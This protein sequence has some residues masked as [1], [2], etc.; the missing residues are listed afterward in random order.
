MV[1]RDDQLC[2]EKKV[3]NV[4][5]NELHGNGTKASVPYHR[6]DQAILR[7]SAQITN[8][9]RQMPMATSQQMLNDSDKASSAKQIKDKVYR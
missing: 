9:H 5:Q 3:Q 6:T 8:Q 2:V 1:V 4:R 7:E